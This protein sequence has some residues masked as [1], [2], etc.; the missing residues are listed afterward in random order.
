MLTFCFT[1]VFAIGCYWLVDNFGM[2]KFCHRDCFT[3]EFFFTYSTVDNVIVC[4]FLCAGWSNF[5]FYNDFAFGV[6]KCI[7]YNC[8]TAK[9]FIAN[10]AV[11]NIVVGALVFTIGSYVVFHNNC[12][13]G[14]TKGR[15]NFRFEVVATN[16]IAVV[17]VN[18]L[19]GAGWFA[20][21]SAFVQIV[22][23]CR[24]NLLSLQ[25]CA[26]SGALQTIGVANKFASWSKTMYNNFGVVS[27]RKGVLCA[28]KFYVANFAM[29]NQFVGTANCTSGVNSVFFHSFVWLVT[30]C[31]NGLCFS[32]A[33]SCA[34]TSK[35]AFFFASGGFCFRPIAKTVTKRWDLLLCYKNC[36]TSCAL[37]AS[38]QTSLGARSILARNSLF[39]V[40][41]FFDFFVNGVVAIGALTRVCTY[42]IHCAS[43]LCCYN[44][45]IHIVTKGWDDG[46]CNCNLTAY[47]A[48]FA[49]CFAFRCA[50]CRNGNV[51]NFG[52]S[53][54]RNCCLCNK[55]FATNGA[56][57][58]FG[59]TCAL[60]SCRNCI[61]NLFGVARCGNYKIGIANLLAINNLCTTYAQLVCFGTVCC[62]SCGNFRHVRNS[63][64]TSCLYNN[65]AVLNF[66]IWISKLFVT[67]GATPVLD[68]TILCT[69][70]CNCWV[71]GNG[72]SQSRH[73][74]LF[75]CELVATQIK[76]AIANG[77]MLVCNDAILSACC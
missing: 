60:A 16:A 67:N 11:Y 59:K 25:S 5:V 21:N 55:N 28:G 22:T 44:A 33:T 56:L 68:V 17:C 15:D 65:N 52:V 29:N 32:F 51:V 48:M 30:M 45:I 40:A 50:S 47:C 2:R 71:L 61:Q 23:K 6:T 8:F 12:S 62:A 74:S 43:W 13:F 27:K 38:C 36:T 49:C 69:S 53:N 19:F 73:N 75:L 10:C 41:E 34:L 37:F 57:F 35:F 54:C 31:R 42:A 24:D 76:I 63:H 70:G 58:T 72:V 7:N 77:T 18:T 46:L 14:V 1:C 9:F 26:T 3:A 20:C 4:T 39:V 66:A 64:V